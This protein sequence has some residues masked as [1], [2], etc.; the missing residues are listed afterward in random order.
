[1]SNYSASHGRTQALL[2][3]AKLLDCRDNASPLN[4][5]IDTAEQSARPLLKEYI[6]RANKHS[7]TVTFVSFETLI[8][9]TGCRNFIRAWDSDLAKLPATIKAHA[10]PPTTRHLLIFD[11]LYPVLA[12]PTLTPTEFLP[13]LIS[14]NTTLMAVHHADQP[15]PPTSD[16]YAPTSFHLLHYLATTIFTIHSL[17][18]LLDAQRARQRSVAAPA[19]GIHE[20]EE[21]TLQGLGSCDPKCCVVDMEHRRKSGRA[22]GAQ[23]VVDSHAEMQGKARKDAITLLDEHPA[24]RAVLAEAGAGAEEAKEEAEQ[25]VSFDLGLTEKQ[26]QDREGVVLPY[27]DAQ[28]GGD[29][30]GE[31]GRI[32]YEMGVEDDFDEEE[33]EI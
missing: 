22:V 19:F 18:H 7:A 10:P 9:P 32:L 25:Q 31:G 27:F 15:A 2:L 21:G 12:S 1:M 17:P 29:G 33:D 4:V 14:P 13:P 6:R 28:K 23:F 26:R 20:A 16:P 3:I 5:V 30:L 11:S 8:Q 24:W